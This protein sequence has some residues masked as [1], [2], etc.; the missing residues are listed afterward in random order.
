VSR[1]RPLFRHSCFVRLG[2]RSC[3]SP[4]EARTLFEIALRLK[5]DYFEAHNNLAAALLR[6]PGRT[7]DASAEFESAVRIKPASSEA[8]YNLGAVLSS[9]PGRLPE[10]IQH[11]ERALEISPDFDTE[12]ALASAL[13]HFP[14]RSLEAQAHLQAAL[15]LRPGAPPR[16]YN[17]YGNCPSRHR[18]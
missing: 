18:A 7:A 1:D 9:V 12:Y 17:C 15:R 16:R 11:L 13:A 10:A 8:Q 14:G 6:T 2:R 3:R 4:H 5:S